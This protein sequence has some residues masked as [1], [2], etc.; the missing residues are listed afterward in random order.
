MLLIPLWVVRST[1]TAREGDS[2]SLPVQQRDHR[3]VT[4]INPLRARS[5]V[6]DMLS[7]E[8]LTSADLVA[9]VL[10]RPARRP[11]HEHTQ[12]SGSVPV[13]RLHSA[14]SAQT[15]VSRAARSGPGSSKDRRSVAAVRSLPTQTTH[16]VS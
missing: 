5:R 2:P 11:A 3:E 14:P 10:V 7:R 12:L 16:P 1:G 6:R 4:G 9:P 15:W 13:D 8:L